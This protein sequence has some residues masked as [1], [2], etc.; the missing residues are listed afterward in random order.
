MR[1]L[2]ALVLAMTLVATFA[3]RACAWGNE[4]HEIT[5]TIAQKILQQRYPSTWNKIQ[6]LLAKDD[7]KLTGKDFVTRS[8]WADR[9]RE[10]NDDNYKATHLWHFVDIEIDLKTPSLVAACFNHP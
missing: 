9:F 4:G 1:R 8:T 6:A 5:A 10:Q 2:F 7:D 3:S